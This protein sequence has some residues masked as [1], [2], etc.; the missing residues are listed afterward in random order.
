M[1]NAWQRVGS[2]ARGELGE[3]RETLHH[4]AQLLALVGA[5]YIPA[6]P[7]DS[8]T[9]MRWLG[10]VGALATEIVEALRPFRV[11]LRAADL[12]LLFLEASGR[13]AGVFPLSE[14][15]RDE[16][17]AWL[18]ARIGDAGR[19]PATLRTSLHFS[20]TH[21]ATDDGAPFVRQ[22]GEALE[23]LARWY[24]NANVVLEGQ[25]ARRTGAAEVRCWPHHFDIA[26]LVTL[27]IASL[28]TIGIGMSPGDESISEPYFYVS[29]YPPP[30]SSFAPLDVGHWNT[31]DWW[32]ALLPGTDI[33]AVTSANDQQALVTRFVDEAF[34]ALVAPR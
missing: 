14:R 8:H 18:R 9:S 29:P 5:S 15:T 23:E 22:S 13:D 31:I 21:R 34:N 19:D 17:I 7:D 24:G 1:T 12:T 3:A 4:A 11:A 32:G 25:R 30:T 33:V 6:R 28:Q 2:V 20:I 16:A 27:S 26:S 10:D